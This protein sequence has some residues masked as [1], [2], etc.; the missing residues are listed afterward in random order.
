MTRIDTEFEQR[1]VD[2]YEIGWSL[3]EVSILTNRS[4]NTVYEQLKR[5]QVTIRK[6]LGRSSL[7]HRDLRLT[8][9]LYCHMDMNSTQIAQI[10]N[11]SPSTVR[12]RL[13][14]AGV[15]RRS[16]GE[17]AKTKALW[18]PASDT[19]PMANPHRRSR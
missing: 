13:E 12:R 2:L 8:A 6:N 14:L 5:R 4:P 17:A 1:C 18:F 10:V 7:S 15:P 11:R 16:R 9:F 19:L 3:N